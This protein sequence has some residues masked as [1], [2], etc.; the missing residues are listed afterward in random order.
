MQTLDVISGDGERPYHSTACASF[1]STTLIVVH[2][3]RAS[4]GKP[5]VGSREDLIHA[6]VFGSGDSPVASR[7]YIGIS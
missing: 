3:N 4:E 7:Y 2:E 1:S 6:I 5:K